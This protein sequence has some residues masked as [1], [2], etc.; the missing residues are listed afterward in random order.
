MVMNAHSFM[1]SRC[2]TRP[3]SCTYVYTGDTRRTAAE[4]FGSRVGGAESIGLDAARMVSEAHKAKKF[5]DTANFTLRCGVCQKVR[6][7]SPAHVGAACCKSL[8]DVRRRSDGQESKPI[9]P[10]TT[11]SR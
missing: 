5:T 3:T 10:S 11:R 6:E 8:R 2:I 1:D 4:W 9:K 7:G